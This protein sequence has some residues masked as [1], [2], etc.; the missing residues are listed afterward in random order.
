MLYQMRYSH[1][2]IYGIAVFAFVHHF[3]T[4]DNLKKKHK[5]ALYKE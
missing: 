4:L 3:S 1:S 2:T 5:K